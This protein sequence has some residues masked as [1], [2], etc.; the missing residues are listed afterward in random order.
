[1]TQQFDPNNA[2]NLVEIEKQFAVRAVEHAQVYWNL[3]EKV[4]PKDL[5]LTRID[6]E[7][8]EDLSNR[9]PE[10]AKE[11]YEGLIKLDEDWMKSPDGKKR[12]REFI[13]SYK[14]KVKDYNFGSLIRTD[15]RDEYGETNTIFVTRMQIARNRLG[16][17]DAAH[18]LAIHE[19]EKERQQKEK[20]KQEAERTKKGKTKRS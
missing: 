8:F 3:L 2:Q 6:D 4:Q 20:E 5:R 19:A 15:C 13:D 7:I 18:E 11:P 10:L 14:D 17:N 9:F 12:W 16:L 1:M